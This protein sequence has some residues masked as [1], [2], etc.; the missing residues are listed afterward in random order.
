MRWLDGIADSMDMSLSKL[1]QIEQRTLVCSSPRGCKELDTATTETY[2]PNQKLFLSDSKMKGKHGYYLQVKDLLFNI[3][4]DNPLGE[5]EHKFIE[6][7][8]I[9]V[10]FYASS[11]KMRGC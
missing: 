8:G 11:T 7:R 10:Y 5:G 1:Q 9:M 2:F 4:H 3:V 6:N